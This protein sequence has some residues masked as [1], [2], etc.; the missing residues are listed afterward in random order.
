MR[1]DVGVMI[2]ASHNEYND[3][4]I[5]IFSPDGEKLSDEQEIELE[6]LIDNSNLEL[7]KSEKLGR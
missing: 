3:N 1:C 7:V 2:S 4:G 5:K 6:K